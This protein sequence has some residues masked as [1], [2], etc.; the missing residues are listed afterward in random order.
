[1]ASLGST[2]VLFARAVGSAKERAFARLKDFLD[3]FRKILF[4]F[5]IS[6]FNGEADACICAGKPQSIIFL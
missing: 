5:H 2:E 1:L 4:S 3:F 6:N